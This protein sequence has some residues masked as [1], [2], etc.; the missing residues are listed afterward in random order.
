MM[1]FYYRE[2]FKVRSPE[3]YETLLLD[4]MRAIPLLVYARPSN[5]DRMGGDCTHSGDVAVG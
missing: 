5:Q 3:A 4:I 1:Q 2:A